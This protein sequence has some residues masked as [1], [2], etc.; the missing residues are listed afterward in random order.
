LMVVHNAAVAGGRFKV[1]EVPVLP[2]HMLVQA[3]VLNDGGREPGARLL[4][5]RAER[6]LP[7]YR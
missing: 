3:L 2:A 1:Q 4:A 7:P 5:E 6:V